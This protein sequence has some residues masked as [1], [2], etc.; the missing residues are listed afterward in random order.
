VARVC[1]VGLYLY[2]A[3]VKLSTPVLRCAYQTSLSALRIM[4]KAA[5]CDYGICAYQIAV[6]VRSDVSSSSPVAPLT[7][8]G[9]FFRLRVATRDGDLHNKVS[10]IMKHERPRLLNHARWRASSK[11]GERP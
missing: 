7:P 3:M 5:F 11:R 2:R 6:V 10:E 8:A 1:H 9:A 4:K